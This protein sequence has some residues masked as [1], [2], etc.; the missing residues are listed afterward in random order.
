MHVVDDNFQLNFVIKKFRNLSQQ[1]HDIAHPY[2][3]A[4]PPE[5]LHDKWKV[6]EKPVWYLICVF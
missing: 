3:K 4:L 2:S 5:Y 1:S 6:E